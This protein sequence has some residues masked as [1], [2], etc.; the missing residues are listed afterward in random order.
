MRCISQLLI[1][2]A[3][4]I[5]GVLT[6]VAAVVNMDITDAA[7]FDLGS[8][9]PQPKTEAQPKPQT[10]PKRRPQPYGI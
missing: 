5:T 9:H 3:R 2:K 7:A 6:S 10:Q 1:G 8:A 4:E